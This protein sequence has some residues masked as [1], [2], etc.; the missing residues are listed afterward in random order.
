MDCRVEP[1]RLAF[2]HLDQ[3]GCFEE[4]L[5][6]VDVAVT[7]ISGDQVCSLALQD[8][9]QVQHLKMLITAALGVE[10]S[11][12]TLILAN[13]QRLGARRRIRSVLPNRSEPVTL[14]VSRPSCRRCGTR[15]GLWGR[16]AKLM[17][18]THCLDA[19]YCSRECQAA[20]A[21]AHLDER[22]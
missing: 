22:P 17:Q 6:T 13:G 9:A 8:Q 10:E 5:N 7:A 14:V 20:D 2:G 12:Q 4:D 15:D 3:D 11:D 1:P 16:R 18:C 19:Y 21:G